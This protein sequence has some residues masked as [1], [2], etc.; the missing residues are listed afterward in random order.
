MLLWNNV[1][2][3]DLRLH[4]NHNTQGREKGFLAICLT[5]IES[6]APALRMDSR[7]GSERLRLKY[8]RRGRAAPTQPGFE[9]VRYCHTHWATV[10]QYSFTV[11]AKILKCE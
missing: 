8:L 3:A 5:R 10:S 11:T 2:F 6:Q 7:N 1:I 9:V 4:F